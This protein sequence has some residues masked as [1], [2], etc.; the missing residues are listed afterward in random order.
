MAIGLRSH[1]SIRLSEGLSTVSR[2]DLEH[3]GYLSDRRA[4]GQ[5]DRGRTPGDDER[6]TSSGSWKGLIWRGLPWSAFSNAAA[7]A[8][9]MLSDGTRGLLMRRGMCG[10]AG[11]SAYPVLQEWT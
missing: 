4:P 9:L 7:C 8:S 5:S 6:A 10:G 1:L 2:R 11:S 3:D